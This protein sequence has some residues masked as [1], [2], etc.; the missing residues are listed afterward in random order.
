MFSSTVAACLFGRTIDKY[1]NIVIAPRTDNIAD[2]R[3]TLATPALPGPPVTFLQTRMT[4]TNGNN[5]HPEGSLFMVT[6]MQNCERK[7]H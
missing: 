7:N 5:R 3:P 1:R 4:L 2:R 6:A